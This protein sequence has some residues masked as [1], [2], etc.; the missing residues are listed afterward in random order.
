LLPVIDTTLLL[1]LIKMEIVSG[2]FGGYF[3]NQVNRLLILKGDPRCHALV[4][5]CHNLMWFDFV[6][7]EWTEP[8]LLAA[9]R[10]DDGDDRDAAW[11]GFFWAAKIPR[12]PL[13]RKLKGALIRVA[14]DDAL[15]KRSHEQVLAGILLVGWAAPDPETG[16]AQISD[17]EMRD[18]L[19]RSDDEFRSHVLWQA[20][21]WAQE[22]KEGA[23]I[24]WADQTERLLENVWPR[25]IAAKTPQISARL[26]NFVF[27]NKDRFIKRAAIVLPLLSRAEGDSVV[28]PN[29]RKSKENIVDIYP[30]QT[31][32]ILDAILPENA[33]AWPF[34]IE[35]TIERIGKA[36]GRLS[37]DPRI[38]SLKRRWDAR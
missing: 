32:T 36:D 20:E 22:D 10:D 29:L 27:S 12:P 16:Q 34:G 7:P 2:S 14:T 28:L 21:R 30:E 38:L 5:F 6:D 17:D 11:A 13:Y 4:M 23:A 1:S 31:L 25:Q 19:L 3:I 26:C 15:S 8:N 33:M 37:S 35:S 18:L 24:R 9:L